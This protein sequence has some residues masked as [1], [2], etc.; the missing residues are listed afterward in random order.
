MGIEITVGTDRCQTLARLWPDA[1][2]GGSLPLDFRHPMRALEEIVA[3]A[4]ERPFAA[5]LPTGDETAVLAA[6]AARALG[7][8][9]NSPE[10]TYAARNKQRMRELLRAAEVPCPAFSVL[11]LDGEPPSRPP[12]GFPCV[13]K[14]LLLSA[15][16]GVIRADDP[17]SFAA[18]FSRVRALL[19]RPDLAQADDDP[20]RREVLVEEFVPGVEV[21]LEGLLS[22]G[23]LRVL[24]LFDKPDPLDGPFFEETIYVTPSRLPAEAQAA[25]AEVTRLAAKAMGLR[26]GPVHA[27]L[28]WNARGP[29]VIEVAAR[30]IGGLCSRTLR[31]GLGDTRD[32]GGDEARSLEELVLAHA[33]GRDSDGLL[34]RTGASGVMMVPIPRAGVLQSIDGVEAARAVPGIEDAVI[35]VRPGEK[36]VPLPEGASYLGFLFARGERPEEVESSLREAHARLRFTVAP[37]L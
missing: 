4:S 32:P 27:E 30:S 17:A 21:A 10:A 1:A 12:V 22:A 3:A 5:I 29:H 23:A 36:L 15:S 24:A 37:V 35:T 25:I 11:S 19:A 20:A 31:F 16:R 2:F 26:E 18:A 14:P 33:L 8:P 9:G 28:R 7:L 6:L 34:R 13:V